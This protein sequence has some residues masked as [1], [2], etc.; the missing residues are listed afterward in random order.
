VAAD[1]TD[2]EPDES[3]LYGGIEAGGT[4]FVCAVGTGPDDLRAESLIPTRDPAST[5]DAAIRFFR[6]FT[7]HSAPMRA[8]G[9]AA[10]GPIETRPASPSYGRIR[11]TPKPGWTGTDVVG[12]FA[13]ALAVPI[14]LDTDVNGAALAE[15]R[16]G[17][18][19][20]HVSFV[21]LTVGTG[22]GGG[23]MIDDHLL[24][25]LGHPEMGHVTVPRQQR[26]DYPGACPFHGDCL[27]GMASGPA[28]AQRWGRQATELRGADRRR[29]VE[30]EAAY[31]AIGIR[32]IVYAIA[33]ETIVI[34]GGVSA[35][36]GFFPAVRAA[37][38]S[39]AGYPG[40]SEHRARSFIRPAGLGQ[41]AGVLGAL[42]LA[43]RA[44]ESSIE[45]GRV[46][47]L[48]SRFR[49]TQEREDAR[50]Q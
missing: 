10:F 31:L 34:G 27:E 2:R 22:I 3:V 40:L 36:P 41:R 29:A 7:D 48:G 8:L 18:A 23:A 49:P 14:G 30:L 1:A 47:G 42:L 20:D 11:N 13:R 39:V 4:K 35:M 9:I 15:H 16:W 45:R 28:I 32:N 12:P 26:D 6:Q 38:R 17:A 43:R 50:Q 44:V 46:H 21:Y 33:P 25:G 19:R 37:Y 5:F 24:R